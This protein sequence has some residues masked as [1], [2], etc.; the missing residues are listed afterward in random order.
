MS[1]PMLGFSDEDKDGTIQPHNDALVITLRIG[2]Y[3]VKRVLVDQGSAVEIMYPDL[4]KGLNLK[5]EDLAAYDSP[6]VSFDGKTVTPK[7][8]IRLPIQIDLDIMEVNFIVVDAY[9]PYTAI[10]ARPW[11]HTLRAVSFT[12]HQK[13]K[14]PSEGQVKEIIGDQAM[15]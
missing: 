1:S 12:L 2:G 13:V 6:L 3:D 11:L 7:S 14:Y 10:V 5:P 4:Y 8:Q 9:S 15:A